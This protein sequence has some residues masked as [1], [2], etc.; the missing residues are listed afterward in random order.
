MA[1]SRSL[2]ARRERR[3]PCASSFEEAG[4]ATDGV[5]RTALREAARWGGD[6]AADGKAHGVRL[7]DVDGDGRAD[8]CARVDEKLVCARAIERGG[9]GHRRPGPRQLPFDRLAFGDVDGDGKS[10]VCGRTA[11]GITCAQSDGDG[12]GPARLVGEGDRARK[13]DRAGVRRGPHARRC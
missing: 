5:P 12:F 11:E 6:W 2:R 1:T 10:D 8:A 13:P 4:G 9:L 7:A 3:S